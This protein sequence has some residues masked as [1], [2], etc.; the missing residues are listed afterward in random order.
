MFGVCVRMTRL[1]WLQVVWNAASARPDKFPR[2]CC[3]SVP[4]ALDRSGA[5]LGG[6]TVTGLKEKFG[7]KKGAPRA[8]NFF[9]ML[10]HNEVDEKTGNLVA[11]QVRTY[12]ACQV[13]LP[14]DS[15]HVERQSIGYI[16]SLHGFTA[17]F[18]SLADHIAFRKLIFSQRALSHT[19]R[20]TQRDMGASNTLYK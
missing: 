16:H 10:Y 2:V 19:H 8:D 7:W 13:T 20:I 15:T 1:D 11:A 9:Y 5:G 14:C 6:F 17:R 4:R 12:Y 3:M 18:F